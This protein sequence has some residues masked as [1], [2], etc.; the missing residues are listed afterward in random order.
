MQKSHNFNLT[1]SSVPGG[2]S[3]VLQG[4][5]LNILCL[6]PHLIQHFDSP[7]P[8]CKETAERIAKVCAEEKSPTLANLAHMMSL[9]STRSYSRDSTNWINVVCRYVHDSFADITFNLVTYLAEVSG[10]PISTHLSAAFFGPSTHLRSHLYLSIAPAHVCTCT[11]CI[12][13][14]R[15][16][17]VTPVQVYHNVCDFYTCTLTSN[18]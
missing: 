1:S 18:L 7:T 16:V 17:N 9:Y 8:F 11:F 10:P 14:H 5:P 3:S 2:S 4:F 13:L 6:L 12:R 15:C